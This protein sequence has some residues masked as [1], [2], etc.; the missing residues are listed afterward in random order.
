MF[1]NIEKTWK[2]SSNQ[3]I[4]LMPPRPT[5]PLF[6]KLTLT[7]PNTAYA[8]RNEMYDDCCLENLVVVKKKAIL[9]FLQLFFVLCRGVKQIMFFFCNIFAKRIIGAGVGLLRY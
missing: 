1:V 3:C 6:F 4:M 9:Q 2:F 5:E 8:E 7:V